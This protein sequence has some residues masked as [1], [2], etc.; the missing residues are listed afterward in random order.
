MEPTQLLSVDDLLDHAYEIF[1]ELAADNLSPEQIECFNAEFEERGA[2][3]DTAPEEDWQEYV[4]FEVDPALHVEICVGLLNDDDEF[5]RLLRCRTQ[6]VYPLLIR[7][8]RNALIENRFKET[9]FF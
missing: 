1:L 8:T 5:D 2:L 6:Q 7:G 3:G 9:R 4:E